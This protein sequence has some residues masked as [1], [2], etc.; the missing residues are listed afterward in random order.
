MTLSLRLREKKIYGAK[1]FIKGLF[2][3]TTNEFTNLSLSKRFFFCLLHLS[4]HIY[5]K[6]IWVF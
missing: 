1:D 4:P 6:K 2:K 5:S 3:P